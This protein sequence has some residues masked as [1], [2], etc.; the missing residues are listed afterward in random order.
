[1]ARGW[2]SKSVEYQME[3]SQSGS[4]APS[5]RQMTAE[6]AEAAR[7]KECLLLAK[8][9]LLQ[10]LQAAQN[11]RHREMMEK[12]LSDLEKLLGNA[13]VRAKSA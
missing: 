5:K 13:V 2:E 7:K 1:M 9:H 10:Q 11:P 3:M 6:S 4:A 8:T 12:A